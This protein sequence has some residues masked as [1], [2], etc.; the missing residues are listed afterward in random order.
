MPPP[1]PRVKMK[2]FADSAVT[3]LAKSACREECTVTWKSGASA[4]QFHDILYK[5]F[6][7]I[8]YTYPA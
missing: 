2:N 3:G 6:P 8:L 7:D 5:M 1:K 4:V